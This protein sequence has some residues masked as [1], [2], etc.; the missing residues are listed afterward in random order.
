M[1]IA[2]LVN[3]SRHLAIRSV[4][5]RRTDSICRDMDEVDWVDSDEDEEHHTCE[6]CVANHAE[7]K[8]LHPSVITGIRN[9]FTILHRC[10]GRHYQPNCGVDVHLLKKYAISL[11]VLSDAVMI[12]CQFIICVYCK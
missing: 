10:F 5:S 12:L 1:L 11:Y 8:N 4:L 3:C 7:D 6:H 2:E 9:I